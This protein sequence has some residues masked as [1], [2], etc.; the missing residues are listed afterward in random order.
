MSSKVHFITLRPVQSAAN[1]KFGEHNS[2]DPLIQQGTATM[3][4]LKK[5]LAIALASCGMIATPAAFANEP[6]LD[7]NLR[8]LYFNRDFRQGTAED[9]VA[10]SQAVRIDYVSPYIN[11]VIGFDASLFGALKL[12]GRGG[13]ESIGML[14][15]LL[16]I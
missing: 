14:N 6:S 13:D 9:R 4:T 15:R 10:A 8:T 1:T 7:I 5:P 12:D 16:K 2:A 3:N 11:D